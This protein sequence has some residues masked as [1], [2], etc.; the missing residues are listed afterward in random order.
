MKQKFKLVHIR[1]SKDWIGLIDQWREEQSVKMTR[2][3][4]IQALIERGFTANVQNEAPGSPFD[5]LPADLKAQANAY[6]RNHPWFSN[7]Q[8][9]LAHLVKRGLNAAADREDD[10]IALKLDPDT[11]Q[12][13]DRLGVAPSDF[14][15]V[16]NIALVLYL[17]AM[18]HT[19]MTGRI[20]EFR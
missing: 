5:V 17:R 11:L 2:T 16:V 3:A 6:L 9:L 8:K 14:P 19:A 10:P 15:Q 12:E 4:A 7:Q 18:K 13:L 1:C 20:P